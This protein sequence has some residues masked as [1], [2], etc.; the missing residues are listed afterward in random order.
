MLRNVYFLLFRYNSITSSSSAT[1]LSPQSEDDI[2]LYRNIIYANYFT[3]K[4]FA[5]INLRTLS[6][7][8]QQSRKQQM[9]HNLKK[10]MKLFNLKDMFSC[11]SHLHQLLKNL[12]KIF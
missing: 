7:L 2:E 11:V 5:K 1:C 4:T 8:N 3:E 12:E 10:T 6:K 9:N